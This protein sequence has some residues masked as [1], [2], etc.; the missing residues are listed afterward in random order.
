MVGVVEIKFSEQFLLNYNNDLSTRPDLFKV[1]VSGEHEFTYKIVKLD[2]ILELTLVFK[3]PTKVSTGR[4]PEKLT[5][6][7]KEQYLITSE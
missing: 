2:N 1:E 4:K 3:D 6:S 5:L 7:F